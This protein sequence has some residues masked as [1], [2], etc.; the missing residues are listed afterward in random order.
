MNAQAVKTNFRELAVWI[1]GLLLAVLSYLAVEL[2]A[3][4]KSVERDNAVQDSTLG[5]ITKD[6]DYIK[7]GVDDLKDRI[8]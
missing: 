6:L 8:K 5:S 1:G 4:V 2:R 3:D 7:Q